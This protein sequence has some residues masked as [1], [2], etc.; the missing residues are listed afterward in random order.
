MFTQLTN[1]LYVSREMEPTDHASSQFSASEHLYP[2]ILD[3]IWQNDT[4]MTHFSI[5]IIF[6]FCKGFKRTI[7]PI[8]D[9]NKMYMKY[10]L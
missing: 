2:D 1:K 8:T 9:A 10:L 6:G 5:L 3:I 7:F 4:Y